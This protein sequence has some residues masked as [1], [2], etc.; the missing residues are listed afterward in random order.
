MS[1]DSQ[2]TDWFCNI[3]SVMRNLNAFAM[4]R[5]FLAQGKQWYFR[6]TSPLG[7]RRYTAARL[8][9]IYNG[10]NVGANAIDQEYRGLVIQ[11]DNILNLAFG[12]RKGQMMHS[13]GKKH[14]TRYSLVGAAL[15]PVSTN[16]RTYD[17]IAMT[18]LW[19]TAQTSVGSCSAYPFS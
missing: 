2:I 5:E 18:R 1:H 8:M 17:H 14:L 7:N 15:D 16:F 19:N 4:A 3:E 12:L 10:V 6:Y 11:Q 13:Q 9:E